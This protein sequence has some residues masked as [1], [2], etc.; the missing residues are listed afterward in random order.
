M[1]IIFSKYDT[2]DYGGKVYGFDMIYLQSF[3][4]LDALID[5]KSNE[6]YTKCFIHEV[7]NQK[8]GVNVTSPTFQ[9]PSRRSVVFRIAFVK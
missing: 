5:S 4:E 9:N 1:D 7:Y 2:F 3:S 8:D 6:G